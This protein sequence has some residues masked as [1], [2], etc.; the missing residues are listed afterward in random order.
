MGVPRSG[1]RRWQRGKGMDPYLLQRPLLR[2]NVTRENGS[3]ATGQGVWTQWGTP[4]FLPHAG[5]AFSRKA[6]WIVMEI[7]G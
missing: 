3:L 6:A 5:E 4:F 1:K 2:Y 7:S